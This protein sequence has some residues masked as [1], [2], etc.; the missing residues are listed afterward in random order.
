M[1]KL[2]EKNTSPENFIFDYKKTMLMVV[3]PGVYKFELYGFNIE[4]VTESYWPALLI[5]SEQKISFSGHQ[6]ESSSVSN[7][8]IINLINLE[9]K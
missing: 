7:C 5:N 4:S 3:E 6:S 8:S 2:Q 1:W 9:K